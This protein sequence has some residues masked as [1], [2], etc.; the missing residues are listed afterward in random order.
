[1]QV[2]VGP[3]G[4]WGVNMHHQI[5]YRTGTYGDVYTDGTGWHPIP[6]SL[7]WVYSGE[8]YVIGVNS[9]GRIWQRTTSTKNPTGTHWMHI[10][11]RLKE[12]ATYG[13][14]ML[15]IDMHDHL[16]GM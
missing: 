14:I 10:P 4:V 1:M 2:S 3:S 9:A 15:G 16:H 11:G 6:G 7:M 12:I 5:Y 8:G 13:N